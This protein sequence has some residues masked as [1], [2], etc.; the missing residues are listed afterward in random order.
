MSEVCHKHNKIVGE[1]YI[2]TIDCLTDIVFDL[3]NDCVKFDQEVI[4]AEKILMD[5]DKQ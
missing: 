4:T 1:K 2:A 5:G 3:P